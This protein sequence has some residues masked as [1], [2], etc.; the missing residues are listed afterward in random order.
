MCWARLN[1]RAPL[2]RS[3]I[4][5]TLESGKVIALAMALLEVRALGRVQRRSEL[6]GQLLGKR[7]FRATPMVLEGQTPENR[8]D[9][10]VGGLTTAPVKPVDLP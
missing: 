9:D 10:V 8:L 1:K 6:G 5:C 2:E 4:N 3:R 7:S